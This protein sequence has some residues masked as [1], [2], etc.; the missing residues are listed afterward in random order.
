MVSIGGV[1]VMLALTVQALRGLPLVSWDAPGLA[2]LGLVAA[3]SLVPLALHAARRGAD[4]RQAVQDSPSF[5][6]NGV[7]GPLHY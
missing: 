3:A 1:G 7:P 2:S 6:D 5:Q 4:P